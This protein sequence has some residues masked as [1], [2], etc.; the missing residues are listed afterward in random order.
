MRRIAGLNILL[1]ENEALIAMD[2]AALLAK[3]E[4]RV[5][6]PC[7]NVADA[8]NAIARERIDCAILDV[9]LGREHTLHLADTLT[10]R[11]VPFIWMSGY[12][13][14]MLP[15]RHQRRPFIAKPFAAEV[16]FDALAA[17]VEKTG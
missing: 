17:A 11:A 7:S 13:S 5:V 14:E 10:A 6:G 4:C 8:L 9:N 15:P 1:V 12:D 16:L 3:T 2:V